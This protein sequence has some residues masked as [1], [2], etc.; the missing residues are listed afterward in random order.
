M[1]VRRKIA[2]NNGM[3]FITFTCTNWL[4]L[5]E[6]ANA[7]D[8]VYNWFNVLKNDGHYIIGYVIM[9]NH[10]HVIIS[11]KNLGKSINTIVSNGKRFIAYDIVK[12]LEQQKNTTILQQ[13]SKARNAAEIKA[14]SKSMAKAVESGNQSGQKNL[15]GKLDLLKKY[16]VAYDDVYGNLKKYRLKYPIIKNKYDEAIVNYNNAMPSK[17]IVDKAVA[18]YTA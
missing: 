12:K 4:P 9:P 8:S 7:Y 14:Y 5:F 2:N 15:Q 11:F 17:F 3:Y 13:L 1:P 6:V 18:I 16:G 10:L